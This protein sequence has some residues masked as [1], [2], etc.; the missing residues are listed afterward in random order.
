MK[1]M[2]VI[3]SKR[4]VKQDI[5]NW[6]CFGYYEQGKKE[7]S[8]KVMFKIPRVIRKNQ[9]CE[10]GRA[11]Q[12]KQR[13]IARLRIVGIGLACLKDGVGHRR[14]ITVNREKVVG[15]EIREVSRKR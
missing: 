15:D 3:H 12:Y 2:L 5:V 1:K 8:I 6:G 7:L 14:R 4:K 11:G 10:D 9:S 13:G